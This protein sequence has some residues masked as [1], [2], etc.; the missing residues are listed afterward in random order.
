MGKRRTYKN[1][2]RQSHL[3]VGVLVFVILAVGSILLKDQ[4]FVLRRI[5]VDG[6]VNYTPFEV[7]QMSGLT[8]GSSIFGIDT[9]Q[10]ARNFESIGNLEALEV[11]VEMPNTVVLRVHERIPCAL[12]SF[13]GISLTVDEDCVVLSQQGA[14]SAGNGLPVIT[15]LLPTFYMMGK[16]IMTQTTGQVTAVSQVL[17]ALKQWERFGEVREISMGDLNNITFQISSGLSVL[18]GDEDN[19]AAKLS[20][21]SAAIPQLEAEGK[22][23]GRLDVSTGVL[24]DYTPTLGE[25]QQ[26]ALGGTETAVP[27][28]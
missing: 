15:G 19:L 3:A 17:T 12:I 22:T 26:A 6:N 4:V 13:M 21:A 18:L 27:P 1:T 20:W 8:L 11:R 14:D 5:Q 7:A 24:A 28:S 10:T 2:A 9:E 25:L 23:A 16:Q